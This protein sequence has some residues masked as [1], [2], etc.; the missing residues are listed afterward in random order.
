MFIP[1]T[2]PD[3][4]FLPI[5]DSEVKKAP[6]PRSGS[7]TL[8]NACAATILIQS[9]HPQNR[10]ILQTDKQKIVPVDEQRRNCVKQTREERQDYVQV[11][12]IV[13]QKI[14]VKEPSQKYFYN[15]RSSTHRY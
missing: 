4:D 11:K 8:D 2:D 15:K 14:S 13:A 3:L 1:D 5:S 7:A 6:A 9:K 10:S 12:L